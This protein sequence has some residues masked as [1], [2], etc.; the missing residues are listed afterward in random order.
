MLD[1]ERGLKRNSNVAE[2]ESFRS[3]TVSVFVV[4]MKCCP[5][6]TQTVNPPNDQ[7]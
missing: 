2:S 5:Y 1:C 6:S 4:M 7:E 3:G